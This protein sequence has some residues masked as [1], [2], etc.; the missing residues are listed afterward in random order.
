MQIL[1]DS[2]QSYLQLSAKEENFIEEKSFDPS[3]VITNKLEEQFIEIEPGLDEQILQQ[4][5]EEHSGMDRRN[6]ETADKKPQSDTEFRVESPILQLVM[7]HLWKEARES[8]LKLLTKARLDKLGGLKGIIKDH[9]ERQMSRLSDEENGEKDIAA[10]IFPYLVTKSQIKIALPV[11]DLL[12]FANKDQRNILQPD[13]VK[14]LLLKLSDTRKDEDESYRILHSLQGNKGELLYEIYHDMMA[15]PILAW[16]A[17]YD[18]EKRIREAEKQAEE[19]AKSIRE[20]ANKLAKKAVIRL[21]IFVIAISLTTMG[22]ARYYSIFAVKRFEQVERLVYEFE[23]AHKDFASGEISQLAALLLT[24]KMRKD[25]QDSLDIVKWLP[26]A[27]TKEY[28]SAAKG[29]L[30][31]ILEGIQ[32]K[33]QFRFDSPVLNVRFSPNDKNLTIVSTDSIYLWNWQT[34]KEPKKLRGHKGDILN[35]SFNDDGNTLATISSD[36]TIRWFDLQDN[37]LEPIDEFAVNQD[38]PDSISIISSIS[39]SPNGQQLAIGS[40]NGSVSLLNLPDKQREQIKEPSDS[41][42]KVHREDRAG[43]SAIS[44][45]SFSPNGQQLAIGSFDGSVT[46]LNLQGK[47][48]TKF[49]IERDEQADLSAISSMSFSPDGQQLAIGSVDGSVLLSNLQDNIL[50]KFKVD[51]D[52]KV[53][54]AQVWSMSFSPNGQQLAI[55]SADGSVFLSNLHIPPKKI[56]GHQHNVLSVSFNSD[57]QYLATGSADKTISLWDLQKK[58]SLDEESLNELLD[59]GCV[60][61]KDYLAIHPDDRKELSEECPNLLLNKK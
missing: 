52:Y 43:T 46:L 61:L 38:S 24:M 21:G 26:F 55:G 34:N 41:E 45:M 36:N 51:R 16:Q 20:E 53:R 3:K 40:D 13:S 6:P 47:P 31:K 28:I 39:F 22:G 14:N 44:S 32:E 30:Q 19:R 10:R 58:S 4:F 11:K 59:R 17:R 27:K 56:R 12:Y 37:Q 42:Q 18:K 2:C 49:T 33:N 8:G 1:F 25:L 60:W 54:E 50:T 35:A 29:S 23:Q 7:T 5:Q 9:V 57:G 15:K 48:L